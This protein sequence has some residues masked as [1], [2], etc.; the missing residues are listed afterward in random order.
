MRL[1]EDAIERWERKYVPITNRV[2]DPDSTHDLFE[3]FGA[4]LQFVLD[5]DQDHVWTWVDGDEGTY[6]ISGFHY[7]NRIA[8]FITE[9]PA[10]SGG[11][12]IQYE[13][14]DEEEDNETTNTTKEKTK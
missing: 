5:A 2:T 8:Y 10:P 4:D 6:I 12:E 3:T 9:R 7:V 1:N 13:F 14:D 11:Y